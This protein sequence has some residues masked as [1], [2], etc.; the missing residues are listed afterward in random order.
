[1]KRELKPLISTAKYFGIKEN[2]IVTYNREK[3]FVE[4]GI[5]VKAIPAWKW[6]LETS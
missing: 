5:P 2:L 6:L 4:E 3:S 1:M